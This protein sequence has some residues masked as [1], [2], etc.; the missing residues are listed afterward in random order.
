MIELPDLFEAVARQIKNEVG[1]GAADHFPEDVNPPFV[2]LT[3]DRVSEG[4]FGFGS[5]D[6]VVNV[7]V[8]VPA[9]DAFTGQ[10]MV[11]DYLSFTSPRSLFAALTVDGTF[12]LDGV[13]SRPGEAN[14]GVYDIAAYRY[15]GV[16]VPLEVT[17]SA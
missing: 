8:V 15:Y 11:Y 6:V 10:R 12:G 14:P 7:T 3:L 17:V 9:Q 13:T 1:I 5:Y 2:F 4:S 16:T